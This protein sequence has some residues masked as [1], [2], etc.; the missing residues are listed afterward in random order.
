MSVQIFVQ[1]KLLGIEEFV[2][3]PASADP[4][5]TFVGRAPLD[6]PAR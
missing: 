4:E 2:A 6:Q 3:A 5:S 1:A